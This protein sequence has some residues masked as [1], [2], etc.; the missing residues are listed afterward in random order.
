MKVSVIVCA[1]A[2]ERWDDLRRAI[3]SCERQSRRADELILVIDHN[4]DLLDAARRE[5]EGAHVLA[6]DETRGL[7]GA[8]NTG[9]RAANGDILVFLDDDANPEEDWLEELVAPFSDVG[10]AGVGGWIV[11]EW[12][13]ERPPWYPETFL[14]VLGCS[15]R[16]LPD[17]GA[18]IRNP[19][20]ASMAIRRSVFD[21]VGGFTSH[22]GRT[23]KNALGGE[24]TELSIRYGAAAPGERFVM[25]QR[26]IVHHRVSEHRITF[27]YFWHRCWAEGLSKA[28]VSQ[29][30]G[31]DLALSTE[32]S[33]LL[34]E[35]PGE[36]VECLRKVPE[37][38][39]AMLRRV[40]LIVVGIVMAGG[41][42]GYGRLMALRRGAGH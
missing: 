38:P 29:L 16:G 17:D 34:R 27:H 5:F 23:S 18:S 14:W 1:F 33:Y 10:V 21:V 15:Y 41:G 7:S 40:C 35:V 42:F 3:S 32:R 22:L 2:M 8:R 31:S 39:R 4:H 36:V 37:N 20:G 30:V 9:L 19:I 24:E 13:G 28:A 6:N 12:P 26:A 25:A 11:P